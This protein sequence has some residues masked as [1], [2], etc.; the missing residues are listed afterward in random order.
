MPR[1]KQVSFS[2]EVFCDGKT[3]H[4]VKLWL[5]VKLWVL[6]ATEGD[7]DGLGVIREQN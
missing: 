3:T 4:T 1:K 6:T 5:K 7:I 2:D